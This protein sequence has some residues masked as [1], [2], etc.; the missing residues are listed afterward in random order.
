MRG[1]AV[2]MNSGDGPRELLAI[3]GYGQLMAHCEGTEAFIEYV[4]G[5]HHVDA[6]FF[7]A[8]NQPAPNPDEAF[9]REQKIDP[10]TT[11]PGPVAIKGAGKIGQARMMLHYTTASGFFVIEHVATVDASAMESGNTSCTFV[12]SAV[13]GARGRF[14]P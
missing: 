1:F 14:Q 13:A 9:V 3:P 5:S 7:G 12:A 6:W 11:H 8:D 4:N 2:R 10:G